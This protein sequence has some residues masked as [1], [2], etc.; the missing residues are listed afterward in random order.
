MSE[1]EARTGRKDAELAELRG[2]MHQLREDFQYNLT[3]LDERDRELERY[4]IQFA[5]MTS[6]A[7]DAARRLREAQL[8]AA[9]AVSDAK[10]GQQRGAEGEAHYAQRTAEMRDALEAERYAREEALLRQREEFDAHR[11]AL[12]RQVSDRDELLETQRLDMLNATADQVRRAQEGASMQLE[13]AEAAAEAHTARSSSLERH[14]AA[15]EM[16]ARFR[17][18]GFRIQSSL[19]RV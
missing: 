18:S 19:L 2:R 15:L 7:E 10:Q 9:E 3:L 6:D 11:R 8:A 14:A 13:G 12:L 1:L 4:D 5:R 16:R 17:L